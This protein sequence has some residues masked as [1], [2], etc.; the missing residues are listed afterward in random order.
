MGWEVAPGL[1]QEVA[2]GGTRKELTLH[3]VFH[4]GG[5]GKDIEVVLWPPS[6]FHGGMG[7]LGAQGVHR[8]AGSAPGGVV[9]RAWSG[10]AAASGRGCCRWRREMGVVVVAG[11]A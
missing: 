2:T 8:E 4:A 1:K 7:L 5:I 10:R 3:D 6:G 11:G 9:R